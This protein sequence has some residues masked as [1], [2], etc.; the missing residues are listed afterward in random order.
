M[1]MFSCCSICRSDYCTRGECIQPLIDFVRDIARNGTY[2]DPEGYRADAS[3]LLTCLPEEVRLV[4]SPDSTHPLKCLCDLCVCACHGER[5][6]PG[7][8]KLR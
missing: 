4:H 7:R 6:C 8:R 2:G 5:V 1:G 3:A